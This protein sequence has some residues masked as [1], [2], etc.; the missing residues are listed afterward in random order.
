MV[1]GGVKAGERGEREE[2]KRRNGLEAGMGKEM[3]NT[4]IY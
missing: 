1:R 3:S 2:M 4:D